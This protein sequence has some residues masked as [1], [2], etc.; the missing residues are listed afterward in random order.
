MKEKKNMERKRKVE[1]E[2]L[3]LGLEE[4]GQQLIFQQKS[5]FI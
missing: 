2:G 4:N 5:T 3:G 1:C